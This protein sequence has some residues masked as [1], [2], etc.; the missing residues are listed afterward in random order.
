MDFISVGRWSGLLSVWLGNFG[1][2]THTLSDVREHQ[3]ALARGTLTKHSYIHRHEP[4]QFTVK[5]N[6]TRLAGARFMS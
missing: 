3:G 1:M 4:V 2:W 5:I 6:L